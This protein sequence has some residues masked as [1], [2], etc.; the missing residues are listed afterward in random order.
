MK[1]FSECVEYLLS[2]GLPLEK[3]EAVRRKYES[4]NDMEG[5]I[6][7]MLAC[8]NMVDSYVD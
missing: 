3:C 5:L 6:D 7:Y 2:L 8:E 4:E 1:E